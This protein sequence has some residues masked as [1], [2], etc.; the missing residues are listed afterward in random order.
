MKSRAAFS[1]S[2]LPSAGFVNSL[3]TDERFC[4]SNCAVSIL[5]ELVES[6]FTAA[7]HFD[8][9]YA[10]VRTDITRDKKTFCVR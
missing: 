7:E 8:T 10:S 2:F 3:L 9:P 1:D 4:S 6:L 5:S